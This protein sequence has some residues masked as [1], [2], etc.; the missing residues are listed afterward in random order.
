[1]IILRLSGKTGVE[2]G[3]VSGRALLP[4]YELRG[5]ETLVQFSIVVVSERV[6][7]PMPNLSDGRFKTR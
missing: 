6:R 1:M 7:P 3:Y 2:F 5:L 4:E